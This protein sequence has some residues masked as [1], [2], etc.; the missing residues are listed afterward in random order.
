MQKKTFHKF[1]FDI[2]KIGT[3]LSEKPQ[4][5]NA[6]SRI[7]LSRNGLSRIRRVPSH[8]SVSNNLKN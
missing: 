3:V 6:S 1:P 4:V 8:W 7:C 2:Q 5:G